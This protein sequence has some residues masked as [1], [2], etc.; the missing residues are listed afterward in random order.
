MADLGFFES[1]ALGMIAGDTVTRDW[2]RLASE[3]S[4]ARRLRNEAA[5]QD[6]VIDALIAEN[7]HLR[8][9][10]NALVAAAEL[11]QREA[12]TAAHENA[13]FRQA[14]AAA[15]ERGRRAESHEAE[16]R[17]ALDHASAKI[18]LMEDLAADH[19]S[20]INRLLIKN[21]QLKRR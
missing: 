18:E 8:A 20:E 19:R 15:D 7:E 5:A 6:Q 16:I 21:S 12:N 17:K 4:A 11:V 10:F 1:L 13:R 9:N 2:P 3:A 14:L